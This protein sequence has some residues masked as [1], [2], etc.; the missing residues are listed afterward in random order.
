[1]TVTADQTLDTLPG[2]LWLQQPSPGLGP[3]T[4]TLLSAVS[5]SSVEKQRGTQ[6]IKQPKYIPLRQPWRVLNKG[7]KDPI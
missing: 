7:R 5:T 4:S 2:K 3:Y 6:G 1:M